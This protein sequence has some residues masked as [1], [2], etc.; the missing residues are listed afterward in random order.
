MHVCGVEAP[1]A[2]TVSHDRITEVFDHVQEGTLVDESTFCRVYEREV[3]VETPESMAHDRALE[4]S[5]DLVASPSV[6]HYGMVRVVGWL[7]YA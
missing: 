1:Y 3:S 6:E 4:G 2:F 5:A 7:Q